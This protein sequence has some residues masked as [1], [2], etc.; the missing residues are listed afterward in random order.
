M[1]G[2]LSASLAFASLVGIYAPAQAYSTAPTLG[3]GA[4]S[5]TTSTSALFGISTGSSGQKQAF[6]NMRGGVIELGAPSDNTKNIV[7]RSYVNGVLDTTFG[8]TGEVSFAGQLFNNTSSPL[9]LQADFTT[10]ANG[11]KWML[12]EK[13][14]SANS[15]LNYI[16]LGTYTGGYQSTLTLP[17]GS[18][19]YST[20]QSLLS[21]SV[22]T[23]LGYTVELIQNS[24]FSTPTY[25]FNCAVYLNTA[26]GGYTWVSFLSTLTGGTT[27]GS[28]GSHA[29]YARISPVPTATSPNFIRVG[30]STNTSATGS[31]PAITAFYLGTSSTSQ[32]TL[33]GIYSTSTWNGYEAHSST[34]GYSVVQTTSAFTLPTNGSRTGTLFVSPRNSGTVRA[35]AIASD[36]STSV[37]RLWSLVNGAAGTSVNVTGTNFNAPGRIVTDSTPSTTLLKFTTNDNTT[38][39]GYEIALSNGA[40]TAAGSFTSGAMNTDTFWWFPAA[41][42]NGVDFYGRTGANTVTR[43][44]TSSAPVAPSTPAAPTAVRGN[45]QATV[46]WTAPS[47]GGAPITS[48]ALEYSSDSG[49]SWTSWSTSIATT[50]ATVTGL[51]NGT[52]YT[53]RVSATNSAGTSAFSS[54][55]TAVTPA[56]VPGAPT[57]LTVIGG[58]AQVAASWTPPVSNGGSAI[59][60]YLVEYSSDAG[61]TWSTFT[62]AA[63]TATSATITGLT[64]GNNYVVRVSAINATGTGAASATSASALAATIPNAPTAV[65]PTRGDTEVSLTWTAP[66]NG[67]S[68]IMSYTV[69]HSSDSGSTW[70]TFSTAPTT[71]AVTVTGLTNGTSYVFKV[72]ATNAIG[73]SAYS[74]VSSAVSPAALPSAPTWASLTPGATQVSL[75]WNA[76]ASAGGFAVTDYV[77]EYSS[78]A[79]STWTSF[80][81]TAS[82]ATSITVTGLTNGTSYVFRVKAVTS[83]G[84]GAASPVSAAQLVAAAP[85]QVSTPT[86]V[87]GNTQVLVNW[88]APIANGCPVTA[89]TVEYSSNSGSTWQTFSTSVTTLYATVTGLANG[90]AYVFR[91]AATNCMGLG[92]F[93]AASAS[94]TPNTTPAQPTG[95]TVTGNGSNAVTLSWSPS[96]SASPVTDYVIEYSPDGGATWLTFNDGVSTATTANVTG[97]TAGVSYSFRVTA[98]SAAGNSTSSSASTSVTS[99]S[100]PSSVAVAPVVSATPGS[101]S[102]TWQTPA[103]GGS[104]LTAAELQYST[105]GGTTWTSYVGSVDL[106]GSITLT[107]LTGG[108]QYVFRVRAANF[109]GTGGWSPTSAAVT[110]LAAT[111]PG[112]ISSPTS[113]PGAGTGEINL[114]WTAPAANGS[115]ITNYIIEYSTDGGVTWTTYTRPASTTTSATLTG[116]VPGGNY[117]FRVKAVNGVGTATAST[118]T[119][120]VVATVVSYDPAKLPASVRFDKSVGVVNGKVT[121]SG[122]NLADVTTV[123]MNGWEAVISARTIK[124]LTIT[125][126]VKVLGWVNLELVSKHGRII[127]EKAFFVSGAAETQLSALRIG[128]DRVLPAKATPVGSRAVS[129]SSI[130]LRSIDRLLSVSQKISDATEITCIAFVA[131]GQSAADALARA[132]FACNEVGIRARFAKVSVAITRDVLN[133]HVVVL[134]KY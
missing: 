74:S 122:E 91:V 58:N 133:A 120:A 67:G 25:M 42:A 4:T 112:V 5:T 89:Y 48:Y 115:A 57:A 44:S 22:Y 13:N 53:F 69:Q 60:D 110:A 117:T 130:R 12:Y 125:V 33:P 46:S 66:A 104:A 29:S 118:A 107:G 7:L 26:G 90:T 45:G 87:N 103:N 111:A 70:T 50:S 82:A 75:S 56:T 76:P 114:S 14:S 1:V 84:T 80:A 127:F 2:A 63:S 88:S 24:P 106:T 93:S 9:R 81:H 39:S 16:H 78:N 85:G 132:R 116:L 34:V 51:P 92:A 54:A 73:S 99:A 113:T 128:F 28:S 15:G 134:F 64:N 123:L 126:P 35:I 124:S 30:Y 47:N 21:S 97:L 32:P 102:I 105:D 100:S 79:G 61:T 19:D 11:T 62:R 96:V 77:I 23:T 55:S 3:S 10:Y 18:S 38:V 129:T 86:L 27:L 71:N 36:G 6:D 59:T 20:C 43:V 65:T 121:F 98:V 40:V 94:V 52:A 83:I 31:T 131:K 72:L 41:T 108:Q 101:V 68:A 17:V 109:F 95:I 8:G 37:N 49:T 119:P